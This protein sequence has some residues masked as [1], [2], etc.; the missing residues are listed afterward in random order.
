MGI[1]F[2]RII[3]DDKYREKNLSIPFL[4]CHN[5]KWRN[6]PRSIRYSIIKIN[7]L[8]YQKIHNRLTKRGYTVL[9]GGLTGRQ[10]DSVTISYNK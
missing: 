2:T 10:I 1:K 5:G 3:I 4:I 7:P 9:N 8:F 6:T